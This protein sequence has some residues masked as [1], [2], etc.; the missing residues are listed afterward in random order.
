MCLYVCDLSYLFATH[1]PEDLAQITSL[2][3]F[4]SLVNMEGKTTHAEISVIVQEEIILDES[5]GVVLL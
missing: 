2:F 1:L 5:L 3:T 4:G